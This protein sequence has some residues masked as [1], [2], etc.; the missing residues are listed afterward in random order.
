[1]KLQ[2]GFILTAVPLA[3]SV[4]SKCGRG[5]AGASTTIASAGRFAAPLLSL[6]CPCPAEH[7]KFI[8]LAVLLL[9]ERMI[10]APLGYGRWLESNVA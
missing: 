5:T 1:M 8:L 7:T 3:T 9:I 2:H 10:C 4:A 6:V